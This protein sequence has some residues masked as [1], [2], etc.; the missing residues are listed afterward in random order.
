MRRLAILL[1]LTLP[2]RATA[3]ETVQ[4]L[5]GQVPQDSLDHFRVPFDVPPGTRE[6]EVAHDDLSADNI[7]DWGLLDPDGRFRGWGGGNS[8]DAIVGE[9]AASRSY[10]PGPLPAG[11]WSVVVGKAKLVSL[12]GEYAITITLRDAPTLP[13]Q[14]ER[15][16][17][18]PV[19]LG[20]GPRWYAGDF[21]V[22]SRE[23]GD[24]APSLD[25]IADFARGRGLDFVVV[26]DHNTVTHLDF[27]AD[28]Q[29]RHP[30]LLF[31][32]GC[33][34]TT[35]A[36]HMNAI[37]ATQWV[38]H[39]LGQ[40]GVTITAAADAYDLQGALL[41]ANHPALALGDACIG[42][43]WELDLDPARLA[44]VE[45]ATGGLDKAGK[46]FT[47][48][49]IRFWDGLVAKGLRLAPLGGSDDHKAGQDLGGFD[50]PIGDPT[51]LVYADSLSAAAILA[52]V[53]AGRTVVKLQ[54]PG[55]PA[56]ELSSGTALAGDTI[57]ADV[58]DL[59][60]RVTG[61]P[62]GAS[63]R[64]R[65]NGEALAP[66]PIAGDPF[67]YTQPAEA[68]ASG[69]D[70]WRAEVLVDGAPRTVTSHLWLRPA[71]AAEPTTGGDASTTA[72]TTD[73]TAATEGDATGAPADDV[74]TA[75]CACRSPAPTAPVLSTILILLG[76]RR[77]RSP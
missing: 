5:K 16:P 57:E 73:T 52:G 22:H 20:G 66:V 50:S 69:E 51:T 56:V 31:V 11:A 10:A 76:L 59:R 62:A 9:L 33:E 41:S 53:R 46:Y 17:Y 47:D 72:A 34:F 55:D 25:E 7:L 13:A 60:V 54:G 37:G 74:P 8:E 24:A 27:F 45:I 23:S 58:A 3:G 18:Q 26:T 2:A 38:D 70:R 35:Y 14:P 64:L 19:D 36:G 21:H 44:A 43:A 30:D 29:A 32:P 49:A 42:C 61:A 67:E 15:A 77:R 40:P 71:P 48:D 6:I 39:K 4:E 28:A 68:P 12:P 63:L 65:R 1:A 75:G